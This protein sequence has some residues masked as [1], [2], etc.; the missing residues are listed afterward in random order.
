MKS[1]RRTKKEGLIVIMAGVIICISIGYSF[2]KPAFNYLSGYLSKSEEVNANILLV[3]GWVSEPVIKTAYD[4]FNKNGYEYIIT[5]GLKARNNYFELSENGFLVFNTG[6]ILARKTGIGQHSIEIDSYSELEGDN[7]AHFNV[8]INDSLNAEFLASKS[9]KKYSIDYSGN[10]SEI[11][12]ITIQFTNDAIGDFGDRNLYIKELIIDNEITIPYYNSEFDAGRLDGK[13]RTSN[14]FDSNARQVKNRLIS[15][16]MDSS[17][18]IAT[19]GN[20]VRINRTLTSAV[21]FR[22][23]QQSSEI[24]ITGINI[25]TVGMHARRTWMTYNKILDEKYKIGIISVPDSSHHLSRE[26]RIMKALRETL[27]ILYYW[28]ILIPY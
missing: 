19:S 7:C 24:K 25:L 28:L 23:W 26:N 5:T 3:E 4:E 17:R 20:K 10:L 14:N 12:S 15:M 2:V 13:R 6:N 11:D 21:A 8:Y 9:R 16:G 27:G 22:D 1:P 18:V